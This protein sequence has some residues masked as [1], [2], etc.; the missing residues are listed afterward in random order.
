M[1]NRQEEIK[2]YDS[3]LTYFKTLVKYQDEYIRQLEFEIYKSK[4]EK[5]LGLMREE[6][7]PSLPM[8]TVLRSKFRAAYQCAY[9]IQ[10]N[11][12]NT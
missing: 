11:L 2:L 6:D 3:E 8:S 7:D 4:G 12:M 1:R 9:K 10:K 5:E